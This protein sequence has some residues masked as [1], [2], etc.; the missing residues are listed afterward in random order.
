IKS[1]KVIYHLEFQ[2]DD[3]LQQIYDNIENQRVKKAAIQADVELKEVAPF[4]RT[5]LKFN[6]NEAI[7]KME[8][9]MTNDNG[10]DLEHTYGVA[11]GNGGVFY[12]NLDKKVGLNQFE[13]MQGTIITQMNIDSLEWHI[14]DENK[15]I[16]GYVC[17]KAEVVVNIN[18]IHKGTVT[19]WFA[20]EIPFQFG[21]M[22]FAGL[23]GL[24]LE[25]ER[26]RFHFYATEINLS[27]KERTIEKP[28]KGKLMSLK[29]YYGGIQ[30]AIGKHR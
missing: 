12:T 8:D 7:Y 16:K 15:K 30:K 3:E 29:A 28:T 27:K 11:T 9:A 20:P 19:A 23:P 26:N 18:A 5:A 21:P 24:I 22:Q 25:L 10:M 2:K 4:I 1:G 17:R 6:T 13:S 14:K